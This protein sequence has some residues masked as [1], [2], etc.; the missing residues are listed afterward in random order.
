MAFYIDILLNIITSNIPAYIIISDFP[1]FQ[2]IRLIFRET[3]VWSSYPTDIV[4][5]S[6]SIKSYQARGVIIQMK[7]IHAMCV[8]S[9][10]TKHNRSDSYP[11]R[12]W[13]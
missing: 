9:L 1:I 4:W 5:P 13:V 7:Y 2:Y 8:T 6:C 11:Q 12:K 10:H 3:S